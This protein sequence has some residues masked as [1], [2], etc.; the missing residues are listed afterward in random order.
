V[1]NLTFADLRV[2]WQPENPTRIC[3]HFRSKS[4]EPLSPK[5]TESFHFVSPVASISERVQQWHFWLAVAKTG[6]MTRELYIGSKYET[7]V[8]AHHAATGEC[9][10]GA[11]TPGQ[12]IIYTPDG[13]L[14]WR[15]SQ[16]CIVTPNPTGD[17][18][19]RLAIFFTPWQAPSDA[20]APPALDFRINAE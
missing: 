3:D 4:N 18:L 17:L 10:A 2:Q 5:G 14:I 20:C 13:T 16:E 11:G 6:Y 12:C 1:D 7:T 9:S 15:M 8:S 19:R